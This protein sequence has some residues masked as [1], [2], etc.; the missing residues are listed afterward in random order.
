MYYSDA[1]LRVRERRLP[2]G[3]ARND[4]VVHPP[5]SEPKLRL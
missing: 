4:V 1:V 3:R 2:A 5:A